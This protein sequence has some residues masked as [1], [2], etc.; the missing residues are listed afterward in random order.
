[1][2]K[3]NAGI[4]V[5]I[6][7]FA[8][9]FSSFALG[10]ER[11]GP[12]LAEWLSHRSDNRVLAWVFFVDK[13]GV[14][15]P[16]AA[17]QDLVATRSLA[18]RARIRNVTLDRTDLPVHEPYV[19]TL[20]EHVVS[21]RHRSRWLNG[22]SVIIDREQIDSILRHPFVAQIERVGTYPRRPP[23]SARGGIDPVSST[24][25]HLLDYGLSFAQLDQIGIPAVHDSGIAGQGV[26]IG[27]FDNGF[28]LPE[29]E[30]FDSLQIVATYD[31]VDHKESVVPLNPSASFG[32]H[33][34][35]SLS[36]IGGY[37]EGELI[38]AAYRASFLLA[39]TENDSSETPLE[40]DNW[41]AAIEWADS[42]GVDITSTSLIYRGYDPPFTG[43]TW[44][45]MD[46]NTTVITR[47]ADMAA[48]KGI[49]VVNSA[50][51]FGEPLPGENSLGAPADGDSVLTVGAVD[52]AGQRAS[53]SSVGPTAGSTPRIKPDVMARGVNVRAASGSDPNGYTNG[54]SGTSAASPLAAGVAALIL[55]AVPDAGPLEII[56]AM[57][58]TADNSGN[59]NNLIGWGILNAGRAIEFL[60]S[61]DEL[62]A[63]PSLLQNYPNPFNTST[64]IEFAIPA[65]GRATVGIF[66]ILGRTVASLLDDTR[67]PGWH[68]V[69]WD[70]RN[71]A[72]TRV[73]TGVYIARLTVDFGS[74]SSMVDRNLLL[75]R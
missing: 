45:D 44:R 62:P 37:Y 35:N 9:F 30:A 42:I 41:V 67:G 14:P 12:H 15:V 25:G 4:G 29:H 51:N 17:N 43:W 46:G 63:H 54:F 13:G 31:F 11:I 19:A 16:S 34:I 24:Q 59:P 75:L 38:G 69:R 22:I 7:A 20:R 71:N 72:G 55:A 56:D 61:A 73:S 68:S 65:A 8:L 28:R 33:G 1:M 50:G 32:T 36:V 6:I 60:R 64:V 74:G 40:E 58:R 3:K 10:E 48:A 23:P 53:F 47:A 2:L 66:D 26:L 5:P 70:G 49:I 57:R 21:L 39:R 27:V 18:R 52:G